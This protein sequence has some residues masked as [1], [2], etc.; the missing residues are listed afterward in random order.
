VIDTE[1]DPG[2]LFAP[3]DAAFEALGSGTVEKML[4][5]PWL[6]S[7][8]EKHIAHGVHTS[9]DLQ[10]GQLQTWGVGSHVTVEVHEG[11]IE[12]GG[13]RVIEGDVKV[14]D[15]VIHI[16]DSVVLPTFV[17]SQLSP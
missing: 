9:A 1:A 14:G 2:T 7:V 16:I 13:A 11:Q 8:L 10:T 6:T 3:T 12:Y 15:W 5:A 17:E 4:D